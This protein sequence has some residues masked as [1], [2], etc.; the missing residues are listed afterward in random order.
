MIDPA[1]LSDASQPNNVV[2]V[3]TYLGFS[4]AKNDDRY[5]LSRNGVVIQKMLFTPNAAWSRASAL[6]GL[7]DP[8]NS[9]LVKDVLKTKNAHSISVNYNVQD[10]DWVVSIYD[11]NAVIHVSDEFHNQ[12]DA[13]C[14][15]F[16]KFIKVHKNDV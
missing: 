16:I 12:R 3:C 7:H 15:A 13:F 8:M 11:Q 1:E 14:D 10:K 5:S 2:I 4:V 6:A 9:F